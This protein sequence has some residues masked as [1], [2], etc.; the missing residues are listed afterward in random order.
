MTSKRPVDIL[1]L[2]TR[3]PLF[4]GLSQEEIARLAAGTREQ[5]VARGEVLFQR[6]DPCVGFHVVVFGQIKLALSSPQGSE[7]VVEIIQ[8]GQSF[9]EALMFMEKPY[10]VYAQALADTLLLHVARETVFTEIERDPRLARKMLA[11]LSMRLHQLMGD[12]ESYTLRSGKQRVIAYLLQA[13]PGDCL[14]QAS[15]TVQLSTSKGVVA[16]RLNLTQEHFSRILGELA[17]AGLISVDGRSIH[18]PAI[19]ALRQAGE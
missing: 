19:A 13:L 16:S 9:G 1:G 4:N 7:K 14:E 10:I 11:G 8:P 3:L 5:R 15:G 12:V 2:L 6:G 17:E 18:V